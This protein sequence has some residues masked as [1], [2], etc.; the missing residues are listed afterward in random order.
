[1]IEYQDNVPEWNDKGTQALHEDILVSHNV[2]ELQRIMSDY[3]GIVRSDF[4]LERA[5]RRL[6]LLFD[7]TE[8]FYKTTTVSIH[9]SELRNLIQVSYLVIKSAMLRKESRGLHYNTDHPSHQAY[10]IKDTVF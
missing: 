3:V 2:R 7:E 4:R 8:S 5:L 6:Q 1:L 10:E 9:L